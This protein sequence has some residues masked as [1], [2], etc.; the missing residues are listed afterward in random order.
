MERNLIIFAG[1]GASYGVSKENYPTAVGFRERLPTEIKNEYLYQQLDAYLAKQGGGGIVDIEHVL[2]AL[3]QLVDAIKEFTAP[4]RFGTQI[5][6][7]NQ[8]GVIT[9]D[10]HPGPRT[11]AQFNSLQS[12]VDRLKDLMNRRIYDLYAQEPTNEE[13]DRSWVPLLKWAAGRSFRRIDLITTNYD[14]ILENA[15]ERVPAIRID[16]GWQRRG[17]ITTLDISKWNSATTSDIGRFTKLHG[18]VDWTYGKGHSDVRPVVRPGQPDLL[19]GHDSR[20]IIYPGF[21]G[22]PAAEPFATF[23]EYFRRQVR[24]ATHMLFIG[25][26]FRDEHINGVL[27]DSTS[28]TAQIA[29]VDPIR[30]LSTN[31]PFA[32][33]TTHLQQCF[34]VEAVPV[35]IPQSGTPFCLDD[36]KNWADGS[37]KSSQGLSV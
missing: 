5:L 25:F 12:Q 2:W 21:K 31:L 30:T 8:I 16:T 13:L 28:P 3:D 23:H 14:L 24:D 32:Q 34:G 26:A 9:G 4:D 18:S 22:K 10:Q 19:G 27:S 29:I 20:A 17:T 7:L 37:L 1:A 11:N 15:I 6:T 33:P 35:T 36:V